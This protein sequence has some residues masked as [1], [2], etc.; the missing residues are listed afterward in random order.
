MLSVCLPDEPS[1]VSV[2]LGLARFTCGQM[3]YWQRYSSHPV[4]VHVY[5]PRV[6]KLAPAL[7]D[8]NATVA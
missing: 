1:W 8:P 5:L 4:R 6:L 7:R 2:A 3:C